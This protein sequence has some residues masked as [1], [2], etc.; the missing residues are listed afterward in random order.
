MFNSHRSRGPP[1][2]SCGQCKWACPTCNILYH[3]HIGVE[4]CSAGCMSCWGAGT[5]PSPVSVLA[6]APDT[7]PPYLLWERVAL[8]SLDQ[9]LQTKKWVSWSYLSKLPKMK[10]DWLITV[11]QRSA[12]EITCRSSQKWNSIGWLQSPKSRQVMARGTRLVS[13]CK[14]HNRKHKIHVNN[15]NTKIT[16]CSRLKL[17]SH[18]LSCWFLAW[19]FFY[20]E[21]GGSWEHGNG[22]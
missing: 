10:Q 12:G 20:R 7:A 18:L 14:I 15:V 4:W 3:H 22:P 1:V 11:T 21:D 6:S 9:C 19:L 5:R 2:P 16:P 8:P 17:A 13:H